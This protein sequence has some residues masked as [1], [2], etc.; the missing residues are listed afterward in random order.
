MISFHLKLSRV[1]N[2]SVQGFV[3]QLVSL[4]GKFAFIALNAGDEATH[5]CGDK[6]HSGI[7]YISR[8][9]AQIIRQGLPPR[10]H[11]QTKQIRTNYKAFYLSDH[12]MVRDLRSICPIN[13]VVP[14]ATIFGL[15]FSCCVSIIYHTAW[16][17]SLW[18]TQMTPLSSSPMTPK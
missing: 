2:K 9:G 7:P 4:Q 15:H 14:K 18:R 16:F 6:R 13:A 5:V 1:L 17:P 11:H 3:S 8:A 12:L 10:P